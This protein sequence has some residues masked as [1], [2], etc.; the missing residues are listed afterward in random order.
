MLCD[1]GN[2]DWGSVTIYRGRMERQWEGGS[3]QRGHRYTYGWLMLMFGRNQH[4]IVNQLSFH[5]K[6]DLLK[7][8][9]YYLKVPEQSKK[10]IDIRSYLVTVDAI[11][12]CLVLDFCF[13]AVPPTL[14]W[15]C[16][17][18]P[19]NEKQTRRILLLLLTLP[20][21]CHCQAPWHWQSR[22]S[23][24]LPHP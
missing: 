5:W 7:K 23:L 19:D 9:I 16:P 24:S 8:I 17:V 13:P 18:I 14:P 22:M 6:I 12:H 20:F 1:S 2:S 3:R 15:V 10:G 4:N 21:H 11:T